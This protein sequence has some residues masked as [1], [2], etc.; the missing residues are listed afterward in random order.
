MGDAFEVGQLEQRQQV[1]VDE[2]RRRGRDRRHLHLLHPPDSPFGAI[3]WQRRASPGS[4]S[5]TRRSSTV[6]VAAAARDLVARCR[7]RSGSPGPKHDDRPGRRRRV[8]RLTPTGAL[9]P[10]PPRH[11]GGAVLA[12]HRP[13]RRADQPQRPGDQRRRR[14]AAR[15]RGALLVERRRPARHR[16]GRRARQHRAR[17]PR[18]GSVRR[19][20]EYRPD[21]GDARDRLP[22]GPGPGRRATSPTPACWPG[23]RTPAGGCTRGRGSSATSTCSR[24]RRATWPRCGS[25]ASRCRR[26]TTTTRTP[27]PTYD[28]RWRSAPRPTV[29][30]N[31]DL[32]AANFIDDG[33]AGLADRLR[34][35]R[36]QRRLLRAR[37]HR[38]RVRLHPR[39]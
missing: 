15:P 13:A 28:G 18:P 27:G 38:D 35:Q 31:N 5:T 22:A 10:G 25:A 6:G 39:A 20:V 1:Q 26:P 9:R 24:G 4:S 8:R 32:L 23:P 16:P 7:P 36:Q 33:R 30:C 19:C 3:P 17:P 37:Q 21:L 12:R 29:P 2:P 14:P 11:P 34:V